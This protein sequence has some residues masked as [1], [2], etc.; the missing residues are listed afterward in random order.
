MFVTLHHALKCEHKSLLLYIWKQR[1][2]TAGTIAA[3]QL[4][5]GIE[6]QVP[7]ENRS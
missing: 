1:G 7:V 4:G 5:M 6:N 3:L 2:G